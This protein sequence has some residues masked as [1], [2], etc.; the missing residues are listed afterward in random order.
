MWHHI[1]VNVKKTE[2]LFCHSLRGTDVPSV[3]FPSTQVQLF[4]SKAE[5]IPVKPHH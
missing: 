2:A 1:F 3:P 5:Y 4:F